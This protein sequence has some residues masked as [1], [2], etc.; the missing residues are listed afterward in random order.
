MIYHG[1]CAF[2]VGV[3]FFHTCIE[4]L[5]IDRGSIGKGHNLVV[6]RQHSA[7]DIKFFETA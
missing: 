5:I 4:S 1:V 6:N 3:G 2:V 7:H